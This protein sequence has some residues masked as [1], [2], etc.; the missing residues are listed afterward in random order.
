MDRTREWQRLTA[1]YGT[2]GDEELQELAEAYDSLTE[3]AQGILRD[4]LRKRKLPESSSEGGAEHDASENLRRLQALSA[5]SENAGQAEPDIVR[6]EYSWKVTLREFAS[7]EDA[8]M[9]NEALKEAGIESW[10]QVPRGANDPTIPRVQVGADDLERAAEVLSKPIPEEI[11]S[12]ATADVEDFTP[13]ECP[14]C[15]DTDPLLEGCDPVNRWSCEACG[16]SWQEEVVTS[17]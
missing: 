16:H 12:A 6:R 7:A 13:P 14:R 9:A 11:R 8:W 4:E 3:V 2:M 10:L 15:H 5:A 17:D 1:H